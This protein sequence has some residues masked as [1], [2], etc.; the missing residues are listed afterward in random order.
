MLRAFSPRAAAAAARTA[1]VRHQRRFKSDA[2]KAGSPGSCRETHLML[3]F[4]VSKRGGGDDGHH[5]PFPAPPLPLCIV[6]HTPPSAP[7]HP[8]AASD[9]P[10]HAPTT[11][12]YV[13]ATNGCLHIDAAHSS[14]PAGSAIGQEGPPGRRRRGGW[15][16]PAVLVQDAGILTRNPSDHDQPTLSHRERPSKTAN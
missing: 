14:G 6:S 4:V 2:D 10:V 12:S 5:P 9:S 13:L 11:T 15:R 3:C 7:T 16:R 1:V 8:L